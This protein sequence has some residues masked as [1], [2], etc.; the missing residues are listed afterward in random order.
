MKMQL[1]GNDVM[2]SSS[3]VSVSDNCKQSITDFFTI[4]VLLTL[5]ESLLGLTNWKIV[6]QHDKLHMQTVREQGLGE[7]AIISSYPNKG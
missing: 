2:F 6:L 4:N 3:R 7:K 5:F 1:F